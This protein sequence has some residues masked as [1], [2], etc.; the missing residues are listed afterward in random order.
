MHKM[1]KSKRM[2][3]NNQGFLYEILSNYIRALF[4]QYILF[5]I[6]FQICFFDPEQLIV[7]YVIY[8]SLP[9]DLRKVT[10]NQTTETF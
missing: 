3:T 10:L 5:K 7:K 6:L 4:K 1:I 9:A 8:K 2:H